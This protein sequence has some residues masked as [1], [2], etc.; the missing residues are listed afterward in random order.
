M[1]FNDENGYK[2]TDANTSIPNKIANILHK[3]VDIYAKISHG[4]TLSSHEHALLAQIPNIERFVNTYIKI[5][6]ENENTSELHPDLLK[7]IELLKK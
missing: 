5:L 6:K 3:I 1:L 4:Q 7:L 2:N